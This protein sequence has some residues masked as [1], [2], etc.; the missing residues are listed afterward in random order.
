[1][2]I[3][4]SVLLLYQRDIMLE[5]NLFQATDLLKVRDVFSVDH[6]GEQEHVHAERVQTV[7]FVSVCGF[8][9]AF[10]NNS[11]LSESVVQLA[12]LTYQLAVQDL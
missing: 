3:C 12:V 1:M 7:I 6:E 9:P 2:V 4:R 8:H 11:S 5:W 10:K